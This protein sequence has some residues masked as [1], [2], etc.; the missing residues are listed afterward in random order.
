MDVEEVLERKVLAC[1]AYASQVGFQFG[2]PQECRAAVTALAR[3]E[4]RSA[5][6]HRAAEVLAGLAPGLTAPV[7][8]ARR[9]RLDSNQRPTD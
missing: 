9:P 4:A 2:G 8:R 6:D 5:G 1:Q 7:D 3:R